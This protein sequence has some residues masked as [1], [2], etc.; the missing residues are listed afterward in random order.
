VNG[1]DARLRKAPE[2]DMTSHCIG[3]TMILKKARK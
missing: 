2:I 1:M 3:V